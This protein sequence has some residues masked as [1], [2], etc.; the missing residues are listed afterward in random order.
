M[1]E[2]MKRMLAACIYLACAWGSFGN[3]A[4]SGPEAALGIP[5][6]PLAIREQFNVPIAELSGLAIVR[7]IKNRNGGTNEVSLYAV[8]DSDYQVAQFRI[9]GVSGTVIIE[10]H[11]VADTIGR[12]E[13]DASQWEAIAADGKDTICMLSESRSEVSC[14]DQDLQQ[15]RGSFAL[16]V[17]SIGQLDSLWKVHSNSRG[18]GM[19]LMKKGH[20]LVLK[21]K[22]P[23][24][25]V[26][27]GPEGDSPM[28]YGPTTFLQEDEAFSGL[29]T[30]SEDPIVYRANRAIFPFQRRLVALKMWEFSNHLRELATDA[31]EIT[32]GPDGGIYLLSQESSTLIRLQPIL[33][34]SENKVGLDRGT[35]WK[36]PPGLEK[37]EGLVI[38][39]DM[40]PWIGIDIKQAGKPNLFRLSPLDSAH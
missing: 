31:S 33:K 14:L 19:I 23:A 5:Q 38:D 6:K 8:G 28:G 32:L 7:A 17:S 15:A 13:G 3:V 25:L 30:G 1:L 4:F 37:A 34:P 27:F 9:D 11:D 39:S 10:A 12:S 24:L 18:E 22:K 29:K 35:Y 16:D 21:E 36:L 20:I 2:S 26:E 40:H